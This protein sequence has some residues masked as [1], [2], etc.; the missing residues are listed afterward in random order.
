M[1]RTAL[2]LL[3]FLLAIPALAQNAPTVYAESFRQGSTRIT[4]EAFDTR[5]T[6]NN[7]TYRE[8]IK[9]ARGNDRYELTISPQV[10]EGTNE[11]TAWRVMLRDLHHSI[12]R[13]ILL[14]DQEPSA[15]P[16]NNLWWL[17][18]NRFSPVPVRA[19]RIMKVDGFYVVMQ[20]QELHFTPL[21]SPYLD[22]MA[23]H[24]AF[25]NSDPRMTPIR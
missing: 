9:D 19:R 23:V 10:L 22:S 17:N 11:I 8:P 1:K 13:N 18:P 3:G 25:T 21:D 20:V 16:K 14:V 7:A 4:E 6:P 12:Y 2:L 24:F 5:L 15:D